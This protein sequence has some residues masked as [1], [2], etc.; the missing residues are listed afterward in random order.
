MLKFL[1]VPHIRGDHFHQ[2]QMLYRAFS[3]VSTLTE[4]DHCVLLAMR[5]D[6]CGKRGHFARVCRSNGS[7]NDVASAAII[8]PVPSVSRVFLASA[9]ST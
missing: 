4:T 3:A 1:G 6:F 7:S 9:P 8:A 2:L 5:P